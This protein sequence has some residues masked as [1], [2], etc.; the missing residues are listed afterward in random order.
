M[1]RTVGV[2]SIRL[3]AE[4]Y[5]ADY[6]RIADEEGMLIVDETA[7]YGSGKSMQADHP[8]Y[9]EAC[10]QHVR[11]LVQRDKNHPSVILWSVQNEMRWVDG[12]DGFKKHLPDL[13]ASIRKLDP[14]RAIVAEGITG[15]CPK[16]IRK[17]KA[18]TTT[19]TGRSANGTAP[20]R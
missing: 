10:R 19:S 12:R 15:C 8:D 18:A 20:F 16:R 13:M 2:N 14:T 9:L 5:P 11:R 17:W 1:C 3:H 7:I 4:P 6:L